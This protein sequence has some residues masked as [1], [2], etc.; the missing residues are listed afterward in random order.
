MG[1][2]ERPSKSTFTKA[3]YEAYGDL[4]SIEIKKKKEKGIIMFAKIRER[5]TIDLD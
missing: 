4:Y 5:I 2:L 3:K 1:Q